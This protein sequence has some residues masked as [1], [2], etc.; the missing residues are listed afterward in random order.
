ML[1]K[2]D[3]VMCTY[4]SNKPY[5]PMVL[6]KILQLIPVHCLIVIDRFSSDGTI[7]KV[8][9]T[10][11][12]AKV[13]YSSKNLGSA[14]KLGVDTVDTP[15]FAF[16]DDD[17]LLSKGWYEHTTGLIHERVGAVACYAPL[18]TILTRGLYKSATRSHL[19]VSSKENIDAQRGCTCATLIRKEAVAGWKPDETLVACEDHEILR[20]VVKSG[21][22]WLTSYFAFA[23]HLQ[24]DQ[25]CFTF[26][27]NL[28]RKT[29]WHTAGCRSTG[30]IN[31]SPAKLILKCLI[32]F[33]GGIKE[34]LSSR[35]AFIICYQG[36]YSLAFFYG[37]TCWRKQLFLR[38]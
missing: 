36:I 10:F 11:P 37:Y 15:L 14:R 32:Q 19:V 23:E 3:I 9:Q 28:W 22:I 33:W 5:F 13:I 25:T 35:N 7:K 31:F 26:F 20:Q 12:N 21:F 30:F 29:I 6:Q 27:H 2:I 16:V 38:R 17:V 24:P 4:N 1:G 18:K 8:L 34:S